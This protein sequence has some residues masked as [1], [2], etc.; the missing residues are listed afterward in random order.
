MPLV[1]FRTP[2]KVIKAVDQDGRPVPGKYQTIPPREVPLEMEIAQAE[3]LSAFGMMSGVAPDGTKLDLW[4]GYATEPGEI[5]QRD[6]EWLR[7][8]PTEAWQR[9]AREPD[10]Q[11]AF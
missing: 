8:R 2:L 7:E 6:I 4:Y 3:V 10:P 11:E 5:L 9:L 1:Y